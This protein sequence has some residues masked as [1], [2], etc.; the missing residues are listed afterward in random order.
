[1]KLLR[2]SSIKSHL[3]LRNSLVV[4]SYSTTTTSTAERGLTG[5][6]WSGSMPLIYRKISPIGDPT[7]SIVPVLDQWVQEG[8]AVDKETLQVMIKEL[9]SHKRFTHALQMSMWMTDKRWKP[10]KEVVAACLEYFKHEGDV[11]E[12]GNFINLLGDKNIISVDVQDRLLN[13][14]LHEE[15]NLDALS[16]LNADDALVGDEEA[17]SEHGVDRIG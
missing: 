10:D 13:N 16:E 1:M 6:K 3:G 2:L 4:S 9:L 11:E 5:K 8:G 7:V 14:F 12:A 17:L 15:H